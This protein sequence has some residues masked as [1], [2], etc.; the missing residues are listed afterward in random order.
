MVAEFEVIYDTNDPPST[1]ELTQTLQ[2][3][4]SNDS[5]LELGD[6]RVFNVDTDGIKLSGTS[7]MPVKMLK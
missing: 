4:F 2:T 1:E 3:S 5:S 6:G 7:Y